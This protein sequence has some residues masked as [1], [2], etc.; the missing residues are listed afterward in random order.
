MM[1]LQNK[2]LAEMRK[3]GKAFVYYPMANLSEKLN[4]CRLRG[5]AESAEAVR[6]MNS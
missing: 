1:G 5:D 4:E 3:E 6:E 2:G